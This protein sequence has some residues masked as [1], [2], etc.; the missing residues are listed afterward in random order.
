MESFLHV[1]FFFFFT[2]NMLEALTIMIEVVLQN[3][4]TIK[5]VKKPLSYLLGSLLPGFDINN[6]EKAS[7]GLKAKAI[8]Y[9]PFPCYGGRNV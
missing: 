6:L 4:G 1:F 7:A 3:N 9:G 5:I 2:D 8:R